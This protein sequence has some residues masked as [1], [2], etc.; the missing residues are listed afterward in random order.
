MVSQPLPALLPDH[1]TDCHMH[2][3]GPFE[4]YPLAPQRAYNV[5]E[6]SLAAH[7][8]MKAQVGL[9]RLEEWPS[10]L[11]AS[12]ELL[13]EHYAI[14]HVT[15]QPE[16]ALRRPSHATVTIWPRGQRPT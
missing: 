11:H 16:L 1:A 3:F 8:R 14:D 6:A 13:R 12:R 15:L 9:E 4:R 10:I 2:V 5:P 7:E